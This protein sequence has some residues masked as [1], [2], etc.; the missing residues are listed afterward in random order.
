MRRWL[1]P[2]AF[3]NFTMEYK[4]TLNLPRTDFAMKA[5]L[6]AREPERLK[7]WEAAQLYEKIQAS[8]A[9]AEK[10]VLHDGPP[11]A[12]GDV[13]VGTA[14]NKILKDIVVKYKTLRG[15]SAPYIPGWDCHGL[16]IEFKVSQEMRKGRTGDSPVLAG[17]PPASFDAATIRK[18]C[19]AYA[20]KFIDIQRTQ[21]KRLGVLGDWENPFL[22]L[23][24]EYEADELR[25]FA[26]IVEKGF[27]YRGKKPVYWSIPCRTALAE[28]EVE[29]ADHVSQS[30][31]VKFPVKRRDKEFVVIWTTTPWT[32]PAN[33]A[34]AVKPELTYV[35]VK[36]PNGE[37]WILAEGLVERVGQASGV[38]LVVQQKV[39]V[40]E[41]ERLVTRHPFI[42]RDS[43]IVFS[44]YVTLEQGTGLVHTAPGH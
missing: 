37:T 21:F 7:K 26:D 18:A 24:K 25:L 20:R 6:V 1:L 29:Y 34:I 30:V 28:A 42:E 2:L 12:N 27:V 23:N 31:F 10:F 36:A 44:P 22:T 19:D 15:F 13:H 9:T 16:P 14:L 41:L 38:E 32:L 3:L 4:D 33:L 11:F 40:D 43:P 8:R 17:D 35:R 5:D 39:H